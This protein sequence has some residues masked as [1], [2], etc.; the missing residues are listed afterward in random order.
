MD[1]RIVDPA[2][3]QPPTEMHATSAR[4]VSLRGAR[5]GVL[6]N[7]KPNASHVLGALGRHLA[8]RFTAQQAVEAEKPNSSRPFA[9]AVLDQFRDFDAAIVGVGD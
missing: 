9:D 6:S 8:H 5:V 1:V 3:T 4:P 2:G 7:G